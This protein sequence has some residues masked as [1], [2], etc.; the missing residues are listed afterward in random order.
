MPASAPGPCACDTFGA[1]S[2]GRN[3][4]S[5]CVCGMPLKDPSRARRGGAVLQRGALAGRCRPQLPSPA[6][7]PGPCAGH[8]LG[9]P[10]SARNGRIIC[11]CG[12]LVQ[13]PSRARRGGAVLQR[14]ALAGRGRPQLPSPTRVPG[15]CACDASG[16]PSSARYCRRTCVCGMLVQVPSRARR[17][18][19]VLQRGALAGRGRPQLPS[20]PRVPG[21]CAGDASGAPS[22]ARYCRRT[23]VC[24]IPLQVPSRA[25]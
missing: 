11:V 9:A 19:A 7:V 10:S 20:P 17:G 2:S 18:G 6:R 23:C 12:M 4:I 13:V 14:G 21:P 22:S 3:G 5:M 24:A 25:R 15:P 16:A 8:A 1:P